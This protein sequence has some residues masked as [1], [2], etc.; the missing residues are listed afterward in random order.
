MKLDDALISLLAYA[1]SHN[2]RSTCDGGKYYLERR[3]RSAKLVEVLELLTYNRLVCP[4][5]LIAEAYG[6]VGVGRLIEETAERERMS[7][8]EGRLLTSR[9]QSSCA[10]GK[11]AACDSP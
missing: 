5:L 4:N 8:N 10:G 1:V 11:P 7:S 3:I 6:D 9:A 2:A